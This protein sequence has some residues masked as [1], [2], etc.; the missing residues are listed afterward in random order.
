MTFLYISHPSTRQKKSTTEGG[1]AR[2]GGLRLR[3]CTHL[4]DRALAVAVV[5]RLVARAQG[6]NLAH[7][8]LLAPPAL[9][10]FV[11]D[12]VYP[13]ALLC[14]FGTFEK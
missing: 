12:A 11:L 8:L 14:G 10:V 7:G 2:W 3:A 5:I 13:G 1:V 9:S 6:Y 4:F